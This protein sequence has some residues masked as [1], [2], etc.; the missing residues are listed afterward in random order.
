MKKGTLTERGDK[1]DE[2]V[3]SAPPLGDPG[4]GGG[5]CRAP[6]A[7]LAP[8]LGGKIARVSVTLEG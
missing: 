2:T 5:P 4:G 3:Y 7:K 1:T 6:V 8:P